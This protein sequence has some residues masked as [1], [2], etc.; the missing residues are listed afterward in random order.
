MENLYSIGQKVKSTVH[1]S[2]MKD[3]IFIIIDFK[4]SHWC[5]EEIIEYKLNDDSEIFEEYL[6]SVE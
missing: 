1:G 3:H 5:G 6:L 4:K 2:L